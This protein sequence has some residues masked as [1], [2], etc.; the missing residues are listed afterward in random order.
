MDTRHEPSLPRK[1]SPL[2]KKHRFCCALYFDFLVMPSI[3]PSLVHL[4]PMLSISE[5]STGFVHSTHSRVE[6]RGP[7]QPRG[8]LSTGPPNTGAAKVERDL[9]G[10]SE[11]RR[12][13]EEM[14]VSVVMMSSSDLLQKHRHSS[15][16]P[17]REVD[18]GRVESD[19]L[20]CRAD[21][22]TAIGEHDG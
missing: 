22:A 11:E 15:C 6:R 4:G 13:T 2:G 1:G 12:L 20:T 18:T 9:L 17:D 8:Q 14:Q 5:S 10:T 7:G 19:P 3:F 16:F 21:P